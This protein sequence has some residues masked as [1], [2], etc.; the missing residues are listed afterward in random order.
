M[1]KCAKVER[2][3]RMKAMRSALTLTWGPGVRSMVSVR[4]VS[5]ARL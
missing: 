1:V 4:S 3:S 2:E 5:I